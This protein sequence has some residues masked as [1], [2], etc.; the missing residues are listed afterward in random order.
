[1]KSINV[2]NKDL[3]MSN[4]SWAFAILQSN[5]GFYVKYYVPRGNTEIVCVLH[6]LQ[7]KEWENAETLHKARKHKP[8]A[9]AQ[10]PSLLNL[11]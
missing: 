10:K 2:H 1:M 4:N 5:S 11:F 6:F 3:I 9:K 7:T 8:V